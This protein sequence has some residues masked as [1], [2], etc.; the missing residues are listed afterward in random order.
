M[1]YETGIFY[2]NKFSKC[3]RLVFVSIRKL[4]KIVFVIN[5]LLEKIIFVY[6]LLSSDRVRD[7]LYMYIFRQESTTICRIT[8]KKYL[9]LIKWHEL[10]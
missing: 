5:I 8:C 1:I 9:K 2:K 4:Y 3:L 10:N 7:E 6:P